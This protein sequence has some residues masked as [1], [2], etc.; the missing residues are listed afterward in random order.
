MDALSSWL[1]TGILPALLLVPNAGWANDVGFAEAE[2]RARLAVASGEVPSIALAIARDGQVLY[3]T[4]IGLADS[5]IGVPA[6]PHTAYALASA[7][8]PITATAAMILHANGQLDLDAPTSSL[9]RGIRLRT[10]DGRKA[11]ATLRQLLTHTSGL[12]TYARI[13]YGDEIAAQPSLEQQVDDYGVL[14]NMPGRVSEYSNLGYGIVGEVVSGASGQPFAK[15]VETRVFEPLG[16]DDSFIELPGDRKVVVAQ[17]YDAASKLLPELRN[18]TPG[19]G[20]AWTSVHDLLRFAMFH[21]GDLNDALPGLTR[22]HLVRMQSRNDEAFHHYYGDAYYG[23]GWYVRP[24]DKGYRIVW[25]EG[26]MPGASSIIKMLPEHGIAVVVLINRSEA[27]PL[28]QELADLLVRAVLP[29]FRSAPLDPVAGYSRYV[30]QAGFEGT[31]HGRIEVDGRPMDCTLDMGND[32]SVAFRYGLPG[33][34]Q[35]SAELGAMVNG[36]SL[37][38]A[39][40]GRVPS[41]DIPSADAPLLLL[42]LFRTGDRMTGAVVAYTSPERLHYLLPFAVSLERQ[43]P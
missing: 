11:T 3:E 20:N 38:S 24:D 13:A 30:G 12:G 34:P 4:G 29:E 14:V 26:G 7:T 2:R 10:P 41:P 43:D 1:R 42:K 35:R 22:D 17:A 21:L 25:H 23:L 33:E 18:S 9:A 6:T 37:I 8:K 19:A 31:W 28:A 5:E 15:F 36:N 32:G 16:M 40:P 39:L 27:N